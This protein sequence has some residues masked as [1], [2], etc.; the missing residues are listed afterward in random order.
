MIAIAIRRFRR[1]SCILNL[2]L[3]SSTYFIF[4]VAIFL[5]YWP[6]SRVRMLALG[7]ILFAN[8]FFYAQWGLSYLALIPAVSSCDYVSASACSIPSDL[9][10]GAC[11]SPRAS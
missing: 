2:L 6:L 1:T 5:L 4:L 10:S 9:W 8:Y 11:W 7:L 3:S